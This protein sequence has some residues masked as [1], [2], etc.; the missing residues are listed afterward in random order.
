MRQSQDPSGGEPIESTPPRSTSSARP[1]PDSDGPPDASNEDF[2]FHLY[3]GSELLQD[4]RVHE[5]K[6]E[7]ERALHLQPRDAKG[8]DLLAVVYFRLGLYPRAIQVFE[9]LRRRNA[10]DPALL[11]NLALCYL[12]TNQPELARRELEQLLGTHPTH[13]RAWGYLGIACERMGDLAQAERA[14]E[15]GGH[16]QM[17]RRI[18]ARRADAP[19]DPSPS[20]PT[21]EVRDAARAAFLELDAGELSFALAESSDQGEAAA[22]SWRPHEIGQIRAEVSDRPAS[23]APD[24]RDGPRR[25]EGERVA[26]PSIPQLAHPPSL[27]RRSTLLAPAGAPI[28]EDASAYATLEQI[29]SQPRPSFREPAASRGGLRPVVAVPSPFGPAPP[30]ARIDPEVDPTRTRTLAPPSL[31]SAHPARVEPEVDA[32]GVLAP[33]TPL[34]I[35]PPPAPTAATH[36]L[37]SRAAEPAPEPPPAGSSAPAPLARPVRFPESDFILH[38]SGAALVHTTPELGFVT[39]LEAI[40]AQQGSAE[41]RPLE[42][43]VKGKATGEPLGGVAS[44]MVLASGEGDLVVAPRPGRKLTALSVDGEICFVREDVLLGFGAALAFDNGR[45]TTGEGEHLPI[46]QLRGEGSVLLEPL[47]E[48]LTL[49]VHPD[50]SLSLRREV[51]LGWFGRLVPRAIAPDDAPCGQR[52]LVAFSGEGRVFIASL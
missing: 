25:D 19:T 41:L 50:R 11:L 29:P 17:A 16:S 12:K 24:T 2:L 26:E 4:N 40:R 52:G 47:G 20:R 15:R 6:E 35:G 8:Q 14:F 9:Q 44:P 3:R 43:H 48:I 42:R 28:P 39:R 21:Q 32:D 27:H 18:A 46:V 38:R 22:R 23:Q 5:A 36:E 34:G 51:I 33:S 49:A 10:D 13:A 37:P 31:P 7:L 1:G 30:H 45:L